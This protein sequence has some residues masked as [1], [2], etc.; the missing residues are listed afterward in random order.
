MNVPAPGKE[1]FFWRALKAVRGISRK[2]T[3]AC[4]LVRDWALQ[5]AWP[6]AAG[7]ER[8]LP[9]GQH[10]GGCWEVDAT[11]APASLLSWSLH[12]LLP[13]PLQ[14]SGC[15][16]DAH[17]RS[18]TD[19]SRPV[20]TP[21]PA[22]F[23]VTP[24]WPCLR[25]TSHNI[26]HSLKHPEPWGSYNRPQRHTH[27]GV[28]KRESCLIRGRTTHTATHRDIPHMGMFRSGNVGDTK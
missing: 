3:G 7:G 19:S 15:A 5:V 25:K 9:A 14:K 21:G 2:Q 17:P 8:V 6:E 13:G 18:H 10:H 23:L 12:P 22:P 1:D 11:A 27:H 28:P 20:S 16:L 26:W 24:N 4:P